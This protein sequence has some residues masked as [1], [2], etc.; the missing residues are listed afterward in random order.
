MCAKV[1]MD[2]YQ[3][4]PLDEL[5]V[6]LQSSKVTLAVHHMSCFDEGFNR[7][8]YLTLTGRHKGPRSEVLSWLGDSAHVC[9]PYYFA[10]SE[11]FFFEGDV[12][13]CEITSID[14]SLIG[15]VLTLTSPLTRLTY[16]RHEDYYSY[17]TLKDIFKTLLERHAVHYYLFDFDD[18]EH[19]FELQYQ[20]TDYDVFSSLTVQYGLIYFFKKIKEQYYLI[21]S[22][23]LPC[24]N[25]IILAEN[26]HHNLQHGVACAFDISASYQAVA[27]EVLIRN[28][29][30]DFNDAPFE[31]FGAKQSHENPHA[32]MD[33][34]EIFEPYASLSQSETQKQAQRF[35]RQMD[36]QQAVVFIST[37]LMA[38]CVGDEINL[39][40]T[41]DPRLNVPYSILSIERHIKQGLNEGGGIEYSSHQRLTLLPKK[42]LF[43][44]LHLLF[45]SEKN[46]IKHHAYEM[47]KPPLLLG[48]INGSAE[49][50]P[51]N[52]KGHYQVNLSFNK[53][54]RTNF[55]RLMLGYT[56][57]T[58][59]E[60]YGLDFP[61]HAQTNV[62]I[63]MQNSCPQRLIILGPYSS[64]VQG[65]LC[66]HKNPKQN[67][68]QT[69][70]GQGLLMDQKTNEIML[71][72]QDKNQCL[73]LSRHKEDHITLKTKTGKLSMMAA[74]SLI[75]NSEHSL[76]LSAKNILKESGHDYELE[77]ENY[78][79]TAKLTFSITSGSLSIKTE[80]FEMIAKDLDISTKHLNTLHAA[81]SLNITAKKI[82]MHAKNNIHFH[83]ENAFNLT[84]GSTLIGMKK[85]GGFHCNKQIQ[86]HAEEIS[87]HQVTLFNCGGGL[88]AFE[89]SEEINDL[90]EVAQNTQEFKRRK[91]ERK[92]RYDA[93][94]YDVKFTKINNSLVLSHDV[95]NRIGL[96]LY[97]DYLKKSLTPAATS[98]RSLAKKNV[99]AGAVAVGGAEANLAF[100]AV[101]ASSK[102]LMGKAFLGGTQGLF[103]AWSAG[104]DKVDILAGGILGGFFSSIN[105]PAQ[106]PFSLSL[107]TESIIGAAIGNL[108]GQGVSIA[109]KP[110]K[111]HFN[112]TSLL[113]STWGGGIAG[114]ITKDISIGATKA[115]V[116]S[117][118]Q[119]PIDIIGS[120]IGE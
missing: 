49:G 104:G 119:N 64:E 5:M 113:L 106:I 12:S 70:L 1:F 16:E 22:D 114:Y 57:V 117:T 82:T 7:R 95:A 72:N 25:E 44:P 8:P 78:Y 71:Y 23:T 2:S 45:L 86:M 107:T 34:Y 98:L 90:L 21:I 101:S 111:N 120:H 112:T 58:E 88:E 100:K 11:S 74:Q 52:I 68:L 75:Q 54:K 110:E 27:D 73:T 24:H 56:G 31:A 103:G 80:H 37:P 79:L 55:L 69:S 83:A 4:R 28:E 20:Q 48:T 17:V 84:I 51:R 35:K 19:A 91:M 63:A 93:N 81:K 94:T 9:V 10:A 61:L 108:A 50:S 97:Q 76:T 65:D 15:Y 14:K 30:A 60:P 41:R 66:T 118:I 105:L 109:K 26:E 18:V 62:V 33:F 42:N 13:H 92:K 29:D 96:T 99:V 32:H 77:S 39:K 43:S 85:D 6:S 87:K 38:L 3:I 116:E 46:N 59:K 40:E 102:L 89:T 115:V 36:W 67:F 53:D 47:A